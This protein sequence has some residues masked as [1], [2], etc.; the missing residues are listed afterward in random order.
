M[1]KQAIRKLKVDLAEDIGEVIDELG[2]LLP[3]VRNWNSPRQILKEFQAVGLDVTSTKKEV[4]IPYIGAHPAITAL[5]KY[6]KAVK[7]RSLLNSLVEEIKPQTGRI[8]ADY[9]QYSTSTGRYSCS[10]PNLQ[11]VPKP[12]QQLIASFAHTKA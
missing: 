6:K 1:S 11:G 5:L 12:R 4:L 2:V 3:K 9:K 8:H 7:L 10:N